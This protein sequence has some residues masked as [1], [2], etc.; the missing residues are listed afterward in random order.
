LDR[1]EVELPTV[2]CKDIGRYLNEHESAKLT[3]N[4]KLEIFINSSK[5]QRNY[6]FKSDVS[7]NQR[8]FVYSWLKTY[9]PCR[10]L[11][12]VVRAQKQ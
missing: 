1:A 10:Q 11:L 9:T 3:Q 4:K 12:I 6:D 5:I 8:P 7:E 2:D